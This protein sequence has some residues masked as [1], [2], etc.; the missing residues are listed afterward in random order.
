MWQKERAREVQTN[1][2]SSHFIT[3]LHELRTIEYARANMK[4]LEKTK[5]EALEKADGNYNAN[6]LVS[7][8]LQP[9]IH[10]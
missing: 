2:N 1:L 6:L 7:K 10:C 3:G 9:N 8:V 5:I 4:I